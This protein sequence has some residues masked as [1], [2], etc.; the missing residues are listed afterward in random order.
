MRTRFSFLILMVGFL[1]FAAVAPAAAQDE[2]F[3]AARI[4]ELPGDEL[5][6]EGIVVNQE[7]GTF[8][9][10]S[11]GNGDILQ[12]DLASGDVTVLSEGSDERSFVT[13][14]AIGDDGSLY[15]AGASSGNLYVIDRETGDTLE[16]AS[17]GLGEDE[18]FLNDLII[19]DDGTIYITDSFNPTIWTLG[20]G[21]LV[22]WLDLTDS[23]IT[24]EEGFNLNGIV[25][26][27]DQT[28]LLVVQTNTGGL[29]SIDI[30][31]QEVAQVDL[32]EDQL[33]GGD[34]MV[35]RVPY[36][37]VVGS[38]QVGYVELEDD[39]SAGR[40]AGAITDISFSSPTTADLAGA[41]LMVV[42]SQFEN[43]PEPELPF[44][45]S[46]IAIPSDHVATPVAMEDV[47]A[48]A[49]G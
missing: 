13:G 46:G 25:I 14:L 5:Y 41:C 2:Q 43:Q 16:T 7:T 29:F 44:T 39:L 38:D 15:A 20:D 1:G 3:S 36:L 40:V 28:T 45:V 34:G 19:A 47:I 49:V 33:T 11:T 6:P 48:C 31:S 35:L 4:F 12:G 26:S 30:E 9:V 8:Y 22:P 37:Y 21:E 18:T 27:D 23:A 32:G 17:N 42:N 10:G 24:Y